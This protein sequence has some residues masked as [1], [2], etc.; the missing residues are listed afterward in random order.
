M[1]ITDIE[2]AAILHKTLSE[3]EALKRSNESEYN[4]LRMGVYCQKLNLTIEDL[5]SMGKNSE[6]QEDDEPTSSS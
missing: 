3:I 5:T 1:Q 2:I 6:D 4:L